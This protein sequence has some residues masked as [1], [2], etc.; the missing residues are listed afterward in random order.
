LSN[1]NPGNS[2][3]AQVLFDRVSSLRFIWTNVSR[4]IEPHDS[5]NHLLLEN[6]QKELQNPRK[7]FPDLNR[8]ASQ[9]KSNTKDS[10]NI[11]LVYL[12]EIVNKLAKAR[13]IEL[14]GWIR[15]N[16]FDY[17]RRY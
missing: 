5:N 13:G 1:S 17:A 4:E 10:L 3:I 7:R 14:D 9:L 8:L 11:I 2:E 6:I 12:Q 16:R 15:G